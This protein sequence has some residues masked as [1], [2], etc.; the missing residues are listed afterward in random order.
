MMGDLLALKPR[1]VLISRPVMAKESKALSLKLEQKTLLFRLIAQY[2]EQRGFSKC[3]KKLLF[4]A[5][6]KIY[7]INLLSLWRKDQNLL[8]RCILC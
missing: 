3:F 5:E 8:K 4:E 2:L 1:E 7:A 6:I